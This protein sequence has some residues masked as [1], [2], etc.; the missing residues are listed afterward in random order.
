MRPSRRSA[1]IS[2]AACSA[3]RWC[4]IARSSS[5]TIR[6]S[7]R[8]S[9]APCS[10]R[11]RRWR[12][13]R[14]SSRRTSTIPRRRPP[15]VPAA[16]RARSSRATPFRIDRMDPV[17][18]S[19]LLRYPEPTSAGTANNYRRTASEIDDQNQWD[20]RL[21]HQ[22]ASEPRSRLR[23]TL[24]FPRQLRA[25]DTA[26]RGQRHDDRHAWSAGHHV[27]GVRLQL[28]AHV[29]GQ[30]AERTAHWRYP[31]HGASHRRAVGLVG[32]RRAEHSR[33]PVD[34]AVPE[35]AADVHHHRLSDP[36]VAD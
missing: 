1:A 3:D 25:G 18:R 27:L 10:R 7:G 17:A 9:T 6:A 8:T 29:F 22:F 23:A 16:S 35:H 14:A 34:G 30:P 4:A 28:S 20:V 33:H 13:G 2:S 24:E 26:A 19:L 21:D 32:R 5:W 36:R 11:C 15:T 12:S 31:A